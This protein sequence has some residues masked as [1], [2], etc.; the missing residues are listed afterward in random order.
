MMLLAT[1]LVNK[2]V[3]KANEIEI[4]N[5]EKESNKKSGTISPKA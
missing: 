4:I 1:L 2:R 5:K 3:Y